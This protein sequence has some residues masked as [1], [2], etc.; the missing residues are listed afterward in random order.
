MFT[1]EPAQYQRYGGLRLRP[2]LDLLAQVDHSDPRLIYDV[3]TG[4]GDIA[5]LMA[6]RWPGARVIGIDTSA[7]MLAA[8]AETPSNVEWTREDVR[9]WDPAVAPDIV[10]SN[11]VLHWVDDHNGVFSRLAR[12]LARA[13][14]LAVQMPLSWGEVSHRLMRETLASGPFGPEELRDR[15]SRAPVADPGFY[16]S[17]LSPHFEQVTIWTTRYLQVLTGDDPVFE[18][19]SGTALRPIL[20]TL[21]GQER[22]LFLDRYKPALR[23]AYPA[24]DGGVTL[25]PFPRIFI[26]AAGRVDRR[27]AH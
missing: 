21:D 6:D 23:E 7:E 12:S 5:R 8:A 15:L 24:D 18:W 22:A 2:A 14:V 9:D 11:A 27:S 26:V 20:E 17:V 10:Y 16:Y 3:G 25:F 4:H 13:G 1:W 19:V